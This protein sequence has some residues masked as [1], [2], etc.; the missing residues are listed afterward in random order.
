VSFDQRDLDAI[1]ARLPITKI[2][3]R[4]VRLIKAGREW[5][6]LS[7][8][9][10]ERTPSFFV[11]EQK[12][13]YFC[14]SSKKSGDIF[15]FLMETES[16]SFPEAVE[17]L[18]EEA[19]V[20]LTRAT[21]EAQEH[22]EKTRAAQKSLLEILE[23]ATKWFEKNLK[24]REGGEA[25]AYIE[26]RGLTNKSVEKFRL[27]FAG[28]DRF[29]LKNSLLAQG[30]DLPAQIEAGLTI[31]G[32]DIDVP[33]DRFRDR[34]MF[35]ILDPRGR[36]IAFGGR[37]LQKDFKGAKYLN[38]PETPLFHKG[39]TLFNLANARQADKT[40]P[41]IVVEGYMD[42]IALDSV[43]FQACVAP[44]G[45]ALTETQLER[46]WQTRGDPVV[47]FDGDAAGQRASQ[48]LLELALPF[49][50]TEKT[51]RFATLP[52]G[53]DPDDLARNGGGE[54]VQ[55][56][57]QSAQPLLE[58]LIA[59]TQ[60]LTPLATPE[61]RAGFERRLREKVTQIQDPSVRAHYRDAAEER[62]RALRPQRFVPKHGQKTGGY[63][64]LSAPARSAIVPSGKLTSR[65]VEIVLCLLH[66]PEW[67][68]QHAEEIAGLS[69][70]T[71][72]AR[73]VFSTLLAHADASIDSD[74]LRQVLQTHYGEALLKD[75]DRRV[76]FPLRK[77]LLSHDME[78]TLAAHARFTEALRLQRHVTALQ[79]DLTAA[80]QEFQETLSEAALQHIA[81]LKL[82]I[83]ALDHEGGEEEN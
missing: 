1:R 46:L 71:P 69:G 57:V 79:Q 13:R 61:Q 25:R 73:D 49:L 36:V 19:G 3:G 51:L 38:S 37:T 14:F 60:N 80:L 82:H 39:A 34:L 75:L 41:L 8:F 66:Y 50:S 9:A 35:P 33:Y 74:S 44:L 28:R 48:R 52:P 70:D 10:S 27:G 6:G 62:I 67:I 64:S 15:T 22:A 68:T 4:R 18:A 11:N 54:G 5:K 78:E 43:G 65:E 83:A 23:I 63:A 7:P 42:V 24:S 17:K 2:V 20:T 21:P 40:Q 29:G 12:E 47:C 45:T 53:Q 55:R 16:L 31:A 76:P 32:E 58:V 77:A 30:I 72:L 59:Q 81:E 26:R 56:V